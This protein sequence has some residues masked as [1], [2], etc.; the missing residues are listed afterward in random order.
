MRSI[1]ER[2]ATTLWSPPK[3]T[4]SLT[5]NSLVLGETDTATVPVAFVVPLR[6]SNSKVLDLA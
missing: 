1:S 5:T 6:H 4:R 2:V 3:L